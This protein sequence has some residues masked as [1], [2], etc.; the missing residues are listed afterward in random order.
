MNIWIFQG[1]TMHAFDLFPLFLLIN[2]FEPDL[3]VD[4]TSSFALTV[5]IEHHTITTTKD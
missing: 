1:I 3:Q 2:L 4:L 5:T